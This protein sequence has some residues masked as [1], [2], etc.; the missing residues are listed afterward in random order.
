METIARSSWNSHAFRVDLIFCFKKNV[1]FKVS[2]KGRKFYSA[3]KRIQLCNKICWQ[4][5]RIF[6]IK[7][8]R[9]RYITR[10][11]S[12]SKSRP[13][14]YKI[15]TRFNIQPSFK[16]STLIFLLIYKNEEIHQKKVEMNW[17]INSGFTFS[18]LP[19]VSVYLVTPTER[20]GMPR[21]KLHATYVASDTLGTPCFQLIQPFDLFIASSNKFMLLLRKSTRTDI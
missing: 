7:L 15:L 10:K 3:K 2:S 11:N 12:F 19:K 18:F 17:T 21:E 20:C 9:Q 4:N 6:N 13:R 1:K 14:H 5:R 8:S 16:I